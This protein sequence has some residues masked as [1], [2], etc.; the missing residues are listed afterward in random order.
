MPP[1]VGYAREE[2]MD[3]ETNVA[4]LKHAVAGAHLDFVGLAVMTPAELLAKQAIPEEEWFAL[5]EAEFDRLG[6]GE[7]Q[8]FM[9]EF[10]A[11]LLQ[12]YERL[13]SDMKASGAANEHLDEELHAIGQKLFTL[14]R[15]IA[16]RDA[17]P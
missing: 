10:G 5:V 9:E 7:L 16:E 2:G 11:I 1:L 12:R 3:D 4:L 15:L 14:K 13:L 6:P 8:D 17:K